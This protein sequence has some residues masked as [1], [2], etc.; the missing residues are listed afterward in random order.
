MKMKTKIVTALYFGIEDFP[1]YGHKVTARWHR[2]IHSLVQISKMDIP[3]VCYCGGNVYEKLNEHLLSNNVKNVELKVKEL[4]DLGHTKEMVEIKEKYPDKFKFYLEVGCAKIEIMKEEIEEDL[5]YL[6]W[7]DV[8]LSHPG[9]YPDRYNTHLNLMTNK[10]DNKY[11]YTYGHIFNDETIKNINSWVG[12]KLVNITNTQ[13][14]HSVSNLNT[15]LE[16][17]HK[18]N[19]LTVGGI[20]GGHISKL[21][22]FFNRFENYLQICL[23]KEFLLNHE[24]IMS[25]ISYDYPDDYE[26]FTFNTWYHE[27]TKSPSVNEEFLKDKK[28]FYIFFEEIKRLK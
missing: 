10:S 1:Y 14:F 22:N 8:G 28:S 5:D 18:Y 6:Y 3:I 27:D 26:T 15:I 19:S 17:E 9:L 21:E 16:K 13:F 12:D 11:R 7:F 4:H 2:Y 24:A 23:K 20:I 25:T